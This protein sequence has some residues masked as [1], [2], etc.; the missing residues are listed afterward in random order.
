M[1]ITLGLDHTHFYTQGHC[2]SSEQYGMIIVVDQFLI[3][4]IMHVIQLTRLPAADF[5]N[6]CTHHA[7]FCS[8]LELY[9]LGIFRGFTTLVSSPNYIMHVL[10]QL[11]RMIHRS[12]R[13]S[14]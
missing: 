6:G 2:T 13:S 14:Y 8:I 12:N 7:H 9:G 1:Y 10:Q 3:N 5:Q 4:I 11:L